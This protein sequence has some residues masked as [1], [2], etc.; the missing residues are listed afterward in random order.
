MFEES[1]KVL[2][3]LVVQ[4]DGHSSI[5]KGDFSFLIGILLYLFNFLGFFLIGLI[6]LLELLG[7]E[8]VRYKGTFGFLID[9]ASHSSY[10][11]EA[12]SIINI[13]E[14]DQ[15]ISSMAVNM[16]EVVLY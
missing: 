2:L 1:D 9:L 15:N 4:L 5:N 3:L 8:E 11:R 10:S 14:R 13:V 6:K 16:D 12:Q 7:E